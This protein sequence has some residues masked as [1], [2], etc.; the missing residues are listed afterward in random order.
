MK[1]IPVIALVMSVTM[2]PLFLIIVISHWIRAKIGN[3]TGDIA[4]VIM[5]FVIVLAFL[6]YSNKLTALN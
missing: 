5:V 3:R 4:S 1:D 6:K 2:L